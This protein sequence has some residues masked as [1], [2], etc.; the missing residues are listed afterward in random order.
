MDLVHL[1]KSC[2]EKSVKKTKSWDLEKLQL[3]IEDK[4]VRK[5]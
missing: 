3:Y 5:K 4:N 1:F 2:N